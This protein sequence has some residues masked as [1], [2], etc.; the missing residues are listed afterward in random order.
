MLDI[1]V[2]PDVLRVSVT[3]DNPDLPRLQRG[4][5]LLAPGGRGLQPVD[6]LSTR[7]GADRRVP[8]GKS[9]WFE[10]TGADAGREC[11]DPALGT[12]LA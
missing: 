12:R 1:D 10:L 5:P 9:V 2:N 8:T 3:D 4:N 6:T 11:R 7:W